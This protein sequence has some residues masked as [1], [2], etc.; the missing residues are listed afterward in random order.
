MEEA[1]KLSLEITVGDPDMSW[2]L[3][4]DHNFKMLYFDNKEKYIL[5]RVRKAERLQL[6][7]QAKVSEQEKFKA[8]NE[9]QNETVDLPDKCVEIKD[10]TEGDVG[11]VNDD[12]GQAVTCKVALESELSSDKTGE[13]VNVGI[14][15]YGDDDMFEEP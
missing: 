4:M 9:E 14:P 12:Q 10:P 1:N 6:E 11:Q 2:R 3:A 5:R 13:V 7:K 15:G 8:I